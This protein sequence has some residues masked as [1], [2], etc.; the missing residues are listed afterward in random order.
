MTMRAKMNTRPPDPEG[1]DVC[2][3]ARDFRG[4]FVRRRGAG[5][6]AIASLGADRPAL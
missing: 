1:Q 6:P 4:N 5:A 2:H 3:E